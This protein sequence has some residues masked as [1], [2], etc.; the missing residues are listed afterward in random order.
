MKSAKKGVFSIEVYLKQESQIFRI[1][2]QFCQLDWATGEF[3][4]ELLE[5]PNGFLPGKEI[6][7]LFSD[8]SLFVFTSVKNFKEGEKKLYFNEPVVAFFKDRRS[9][10]RESVEQS[11]FLTVSGSEESRYSLYNLSPNGLSFFKSK[12]LGSKFDEGTSLEK[13]KLSWRGGE[14]DI[15]LS[16]VGVRNY[17]LYENEERPF[18]RSIISCTF[19][20]PSKKKLLNLI[21][22]VQKDFSP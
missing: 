7:I 6:K 22:L 8:L 15:G 2:A 1:P 12:N 14:L 13:C 5:M 10:E 16:I 20:N 18:I 19:I 9:E 21:S 11:I 17:D 4:L 3:E